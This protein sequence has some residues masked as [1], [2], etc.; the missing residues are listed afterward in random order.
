MS[1]LQVRTMNSCS[2]CGSRGKPVPGQTVKA[3]LAASLRLVRDVRY[4][5]CRT[6]N[7]S[8]VY[9]SDDGA[10]T[11]TLNDVRERVYQKE[12]DDDGV[13]VCYCFQHKVGDLRVAS[14][15]ARNAIVN[16]I[17]AGIS[18][19]Q[20]ACDLRNPQGTCCLGNVLELTKRFE[21]SKE[22]AR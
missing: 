19:N 14:F 22:S 13:L 16:D 20:C 11:F 10:Q 5:F 9:F 7:C 1:F 21:E 12:P 6:R 15:H 18:A 4:L 2:E 3:L 8:V 17:N